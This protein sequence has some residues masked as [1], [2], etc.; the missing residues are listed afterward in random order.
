MAGALLNSALG[1]KE[2]SPTNL[3]TGKLF[4]ALS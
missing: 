3:K 1:D 4:Q 2:T